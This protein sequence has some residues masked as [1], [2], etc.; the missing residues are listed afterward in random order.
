[1]QM[2]ALYD[3]SPIRFGKDDCG[4]DGFDLRFADRSFELDID[5]RHFQE[6]LEPDVAFGQSDEP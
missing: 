4:N 6:D 3:S 2:E 1:M 5:G